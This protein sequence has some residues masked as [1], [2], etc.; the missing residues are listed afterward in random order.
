MGRI[1]QISVEPLT[2][3]AFRPFGELISATDR[4]ADFHGVN[5]KGWKAGFE[6]DGPP[7][8]MLLSS[9]NEG[10]QF[11]QARAPFW[12]HAD[13]HSA[14][15]GARGRRGGRTRPTP[16]TRPRFR[17]RRRCEVFLIDGSA[18]YVLKRGTWHSLD[19]YPL[20]RAGI[21]D[22]DHHRTSAPRMN[23]RMPRAI[24]GS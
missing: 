10:L 2:E 14:R 23:S 22:R 16:T 7:L 5:S 17:R 9:R 21:T 13:I 18:G 3:E 15:A 1:V 12:R 6:V 8:V 4:P 20:S 19:R 11:T 24:S